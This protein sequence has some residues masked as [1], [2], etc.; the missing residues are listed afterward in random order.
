MT[1]GAVTG[2]ASASSTAETANASASGEVHSLSLFGGEVTAQTV[3]ARAAASARDGSASG[4][5]SGTSVT[6][7]VIGGQAVEPTPGLRAAL[8]DWGYALVLAQGEAPADEGTAAS[9]PPSRSTGPRPRRAPGRDGDRVGYA[10]GRPPP[11]RRS[12]RRPAPRAARRRRQEATVVG[13]GAARIEGAGRAPPGP[14]D[15]AEADQERLRL[16]GATA[17]RRSSTRSAPGRADI[18]WHHGEDIFAPIG[19][20]VLA[21]ADG[22]RLLGRL[23]RPRRQ[24]PLAPRREGQRVLLRAPVRVLAA[25]GRRRARP[26][27]DVLGFVGNSGDA[28]TTPPHLHFEIHPVGLLAWATTA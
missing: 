12:R 17:R 24:P 5:L 3:S 11:P 18:G 26:G 6:G 2:S 27:G 10:E 4:D 19:A 28:E 25:R 1:S 14:D 15:R 13:G 8:G 9:S 21:V 22:T 16:P 20:P 7:L 23:E